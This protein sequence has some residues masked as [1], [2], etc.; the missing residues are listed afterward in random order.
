MV[1]WSELK[2]MNMESLL[3]K[4]EEYM[5]E[6]ELIAEGCVSKINNLISN[7]DMNKTET[8]E[9][10]LCLLFKYYVCIC[11]NEYEEEMT[12]EDKIEYLYWEEFIDEDTRNKLLYL[13][14]VVDDIYKIDRKNDA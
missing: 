3:S 11:N 6:K 9:E 14:K 5:F 2:E 4:N 7:K 8:I 1:I 10:I 13:C 12:L